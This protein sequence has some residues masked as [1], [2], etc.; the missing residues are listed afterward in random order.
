M[1]VLP[2]GGCNNPNYGL[3]DEAAPGPVGRLLRQMWLAEQVGKE[4][5]VQGGLGAWGRGL[6]APAF[7]LQACSPRPPRHPGCSYQS[8]LGWAGKGKKQAHTQDILRKRPAS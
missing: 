4:K 3:S 8:I 5:C 7:T 6:Q 2:M 1:S